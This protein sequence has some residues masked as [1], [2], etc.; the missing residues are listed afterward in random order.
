MSRL[1]TQARRQ[2]RSHQ[3][4]TRIARRVTQRDGLPAPSSTSSQTRPGWLQS[5]SQVP[6]SSRRDRTWSI[7]SPSLGS[8][9][10]PVRLAAERK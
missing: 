6:S 8:G 9:A 1:A 2:A 3:L 5:R 7:A 4:S 10:A